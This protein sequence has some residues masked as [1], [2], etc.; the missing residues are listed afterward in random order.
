MHCRIGFVS[1]ALARA[2]ADG[3]AVHTCR[4][5]RQRSQLADFLAH[6]S[7]TDGVANW[8]PL[9]QPTPEARHSARAGRREPELAMTC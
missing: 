3:R 1:P 8:A 7:L 5:P 6:L 9:S 2:R 4:A